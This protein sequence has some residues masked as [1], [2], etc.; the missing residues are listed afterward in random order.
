MDEAGLESAL[1]WYIEGF[2]DRS[3]ITTTLEIPQSLTKLSRQ[4]EL[5]VFRVV[6]ECLTNI[7]RHANSPTA[8]IRIMQDSDFLR[9]QVEDE[10]KGISTEKLATLRSSS[11]TGVGIREMRERLRHL[12]GTLH[13]ESHPRGTQI[14]AILPL[15]GK[16]GTPPTDK[17]SSIN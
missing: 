4:L 15:T 16:P 2:A 8:R 17:M 11:R 3:K 13:I 10:G 1:N 6:Q 9:V 5:S 12:G 14:T 7:H